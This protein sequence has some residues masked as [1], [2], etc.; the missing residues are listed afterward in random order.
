MDTMEEG[1]VNFPCL[2]PMYMVYV[3]VHGEQMA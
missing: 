2:G 1:A 3:F